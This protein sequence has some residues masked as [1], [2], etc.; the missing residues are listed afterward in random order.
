MSAMLVGLATAPALAN[1][2]TTTAVD[3]DGDGIAEAAQTTTT[4]KA[5]KTTK[6]YKTYKKTLDP[7]E[8]DKDG[9]N[10]LSMAEIGEGL[11]FIYDTDGNEVVDNIEYN[12]NVVATV[13]PVEVEQ[14][15]FIDM[16]GDG[17]SEATTYD[18]ERFMQY[19]KLSMFDKD[20]DGLTGEDFLKMSFLEADDDSDGVL[21]LE[22]WSE[23][24][25]PREAPLNAERER[26]QD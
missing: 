24:Y 12:S 8:F 16:D 9:D 13:T 5:T 19:T 22:E 17:V 20:K 25:L 14:Y 18:Y 7:V 2:T 6:T 1:T 15:E 4:T 10:R 21:T 3:T 23:E 11:F 26:Y